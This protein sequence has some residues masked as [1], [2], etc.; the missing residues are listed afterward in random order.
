MSRLL[1]TCPY[2]QPLAFRVGEQA[3]VRIIR[4]E[5]VMAQP[6]WML[7][8]ERMSPFIIVGRGMISP[9]LRQR[10][11]AAIGGS[12]LLS[13]LERE[14][15]PVDAMLVKGAVFSLRRLLLAQIDFAAW[16]RVAHTE[17][18]LPDRRIYQRRQRAIELYVA[19]EPI[20]AIERRTQV[21]R[22]TLYRLLKVCLAPHPDGRL[23]GFGAL[24]PRH[25]VRNYRRQSATQ[26]TSRTG[27]RG[28]VGACH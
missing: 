3:S 15:A 21:D 27:H 17:L 9:A 1:R 20:E 23:Q 14:M 18:P 25:P 2:L 26:L 10:I 13:N 4:R 12:K 24:A 11:L 19:A 5:D 22:S 6:T 28:L 7:T 16:A 8:W